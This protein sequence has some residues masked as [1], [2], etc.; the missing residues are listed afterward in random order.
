MLP[1][2]AT[3]VLFRL[4]AAALAV[5]LGSCGKDPAPEAAPQQPA[6]QPAG[7]TAP[8]AAAA[9]EPVSYGRHIRPLLSDQCFK[10]HGPDEAT[11]EAGLRLDVRDGA[12]ADLGGYAAIVPG[13]PA[14]S[15]L[16]ARIAHHDPDE[17]MPPPST[18]KK[19]FR[20]EQ[21]ALIARWIAEGA[22]YESHWSFVPPTRPEVPAVPAGVTAANPVDHFV[23]HELAQAG[24]SPSPEAD[25][26]TLARR[27]FLTLTGLPPTTT[28]LDEHLA[29]GSADAWTRLVDKLLTQEPYRSR[30]AERMAT[31][32]LDAARYADTSGIHMDAGRQMWAWRD[33]LLQAY[34]DNMPFDQFVT[35]QIAGDLLPDA[36]L[37]QKV[38]SGFHRNHVT[39]DEGGAIAEEY[40]V[41]YAA[42]RTATTGQVLL[43]L[44]VGCARCHDH[45]Y[46]P[47]SQKEYFSLFA[48]FNSIEEPGLYSQVADPNR[49]FEP[50]LDVPRPQQQEQV[51]Q[52]EQELAAARTAL[53]AEPADEA[54]Q[55]TRFLAE[56][57][58]ASSLQWAATSAVSATSTNGATLAV[59]P[60]GSVLASGA[61]PDKD[62]H[63][64]NLRTE[65]S[66]LRM[67][68]LEALP[69]ASLPGGR[70][71]RAPNGNAV[72]NH[73]SL[74]AISVKDPAQRRSVPLTWA[75]ADLQQANGDFHVVHA[76][77]DKDNLGWAVDGHNG[78]PAPR[79]ALFVA[80]ED[81]G[82]EGGT[83]L[84]VT[85]Q[86]DSIYAQHTFGCVRLG[87]GAVAESA[88]A[89]L[90]LARSGFYRAGPFSGTRDEVWGR[91]YGPELAAAIDRGQTFG[92]AKRRWQH[93]P[94]YAEGRVNGL[95]DGT[96]AFYLAQEVF[97]A[98]PRTQEWSLGSD[99]GFRLF[100]S[101]RQVAAEQVDRAA[102][103]DQNR[104]SAEVPAGSSLLVMK[105][106]NT[107]GNGG[108]Y[109]RQLP[110][111]D[112]L[113]GDMVAA[114]LPAQARHPALD[115]RLNVAWR[116]TFSPGY[117]E[118]RKR[119]AD[120]EQEIA[121]LRAGTPRTMVMKELQQPRETFVLMRGAYD[122]PDRNQPVQR[123]IPAALGK[124]P[125][126]A[127]ANRLGLAQWLVSPD[128][129]LVARVAVNR[130]WE[131]VFGTGIVRTS[132]DFGLQ[133]EWPSHPELLDW[134][135]VELREHQWDIRHVL[136][137]MVTSATYRQSSRVR[138]DVRSVDPDNRLLGW[139]PR[140]RLGAEEIRDQ[141]LYVS[142]LLVE[143]LG[144]PSVKTYQ[145]EGL[146]QE[147]A[148]PQSNTRVFQRDNG[149]ALWRRSLYT[150][151]K[152]AAPPPNLVTFDAPTRE[153]CTT[154]RITTNTPL[155]ALVLWND[156][157]FVECSRVMAE[158]LL[159]GEGTDRARLENGYRS[160]TGQQ[161]GDTEMA[162][163][164]GALD[165]FRER[166]RDDEAA[167]RTLVEVGE[168]PAA[169]LPPTEVA[170][171]TMVCNALL[172]LDATIC[173]D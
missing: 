84:V 147:V 162:A 88:L 141:A 134:L 170:A 14:G 166:Y 104:A 40:L 18:G 87:V 75:W 155:Q 143:E 86:Y 44:T 65:A 71:G 159:A 173:V 4:H 99:D 124:L 59:Q 93:I 56:L 20:E 113:A 90:P 97:S 67:L 108:F 54:E 149:N 146:W 123:G 89:R 35:E 53:A 94:E 34:R 12:T 161:P 116:E 131:M 2:N 8:V 61:N 49:A 79:T 115:A 69:H 24:F 17:V 23:A 58:T 111:A 140:R 19:P 109:V 77:A 10:C 70:V 164:E 160:T 47:V 64:V 83:D 78:A 43:G 103:P 169:T 96:N 68:S 33:W 51:Q 153:F 133:G 154:R 135:A 52:K 102:A 45:K 121:Q 66:R 32:W 80:A 156:E 82:F 13:D 91:E 114:L 25:R 26:A 100:L 29:D 27:L 63:V 73:V 42:D 16:L 130:L 138:E 172:N 36:T 37:A 167:A 11:R 5:V 137:L 30:H 76:L 171:W 145:P 31:P 62:T 144:G 112:E 127:P 74:E 122:K 107:G 7:A 72:L 50:F 1:P 57:A 117:R 136:R 9:V 98:A 139:Y 101:G 22:N 165:A 60:D 106:V 55:R 142:G 110:G 148:M 15:E 151:W 152:R 128:N 118:R 38:A 126:G 95:Q 163:L 132:D 168:R 129:P 21:R 39:T 6:G 85:L 28:E 92:G 157:Q 41:E 81:F 46:D 3:R 150:Y 48:Y 125:E 158:H 105:I 119:V 120:L